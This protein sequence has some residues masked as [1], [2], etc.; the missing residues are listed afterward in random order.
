VLVPG[1]PG[2]DLIRIRFRRRSTFD[3][4]ATP[5]VAEAEGTGTLADVDLA[6]HQGA[7]GRDHREGEGRGPQ[8]AA[9]AH[10]AAR[11]VLREW[12]PPRVPDRGAGR[13]A[14]RGARRRADA[15]RRLP[16]DV[17]DS[18]SRSW[19]TSTRRLHQY[20][21]ELPTEGKQGQPTTRRSAPR[22]TSTSSTT[23]RAPVAGS[24][25]HREKNPPSARET[26]PAADGGPAKGKAQRTFLLDNNEDTLHPWRD[27]IAATAADTLQ[28]HD[29]LP[30]T[31]PL[32]VWL[33]FTF[34]RPPTH[35]R[36]G[37]NAHR[38]TN[39]APTFPGHGCG[40]I[41]KLT[42][43]V[44]DALTRPRSGS[45]SG[46]WA[47]DTQVVDVRARKFYAGEDELALDR[48][49]VDVVIED[50]TPQ[51]SAAPVTSTPTGSADPQG[52]L[53]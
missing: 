25:A 44:L 29:G 4:G 34:T 12:T 16:R 42:R 33:R 2:L 40:D 22:A 15:D 6:A 1:V 32:R 49:G 24:S 48:P 51:T 27:L 45:W 52:A 9:Q 47:D 23:G 10:R 35:Y 17:V 43:A 36:S 18:C 20:P 53:L 38:L 14:G 39:Q 8:G 5:K 21:A 11:G 13:R 26:R 41:D 28:Y 3:S 19:R 31:G 46:A 37:R 7:D 50:L 30:L